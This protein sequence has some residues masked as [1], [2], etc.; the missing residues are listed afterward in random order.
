MTEIHW[1]TYNQLARALIRHRAKEAKGGFNNY[2]YPWL[3]LLATRNNGGTINKI[4][5]IKENTDKLE[6]GEEYRKIE[7]CYRMSNIS[8]KEMITSSIELMR[9][10]YTVVGLTR[11]GDF[12]RLDMTHHNNGPVEQELHRMNKDMLF[13]T[14]ELS[15]I[16]IKGGFKIIYRSKNGK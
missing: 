11:V 13:M 9:E 16:Y 3:F 5:R 14:V 8:A 10:G 7:Q 4:H 15:G 12:H 1:K 2:R 6:P